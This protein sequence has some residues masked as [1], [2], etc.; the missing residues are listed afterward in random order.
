MHLVLNGV[1]FTIG[2]A[3]LQLA[4]GPSVVVVLAELVDQVHDVLVQLHPVGGSI[5]L[6][7]RVSNV[8]VIVLLALL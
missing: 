4:R 2:P 1:G 7:R 6:D 8:L 5:V 3:A